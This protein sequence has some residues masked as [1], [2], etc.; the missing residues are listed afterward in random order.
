MNDYIYATQLLQAE[1]L[2]A[3]FTLWR[4]RFGGHGRELTSGALVWQYVRVVC[5]RA[6][7]AGSTTAGR[8]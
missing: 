4:R 2:T 3:A 6:D 7:R 5:L 8:A 1:A